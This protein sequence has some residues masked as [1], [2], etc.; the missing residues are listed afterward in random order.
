MIGED[1]PDAASADYTEWRNK[2]IFA[3]LNGGDKNNPTN[4]STI[5][6]NKDHAERALAYDVAIGLC[7]LTE[8]DFE[9][10]RLQA[11]WRFASEVMKGDP[12]LSW[13]II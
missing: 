6:T 13:L 9:N 10:A 2:E 3:I 4:H 5:M 11:D 7:Y 8:D 12:N 1:N